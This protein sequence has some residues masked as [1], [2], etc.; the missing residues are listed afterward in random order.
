MVL[1]HEIDQSRLNQL[2]SFTVFH[3]SIQFACLDQPFEAAR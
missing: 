1:R 3:E 2:I